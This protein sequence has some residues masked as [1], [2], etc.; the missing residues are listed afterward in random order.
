MLLN[1]ITCSRIVYSKAS[2]VVIY[3]VFLNFT[4]YTR[5]YI[6][7]CHLRFIEIQSQNIRVLK[8]E[9]LLL[10]LHSY[11]SKQTHLGLTKTRIKVAK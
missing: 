3:K 10:M 5:G 9:K 2:D 11:S 7:Q 1:K 6:S 4:Y 8:W